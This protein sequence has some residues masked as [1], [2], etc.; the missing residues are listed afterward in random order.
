MP[1]ITASI[2]PITRIEGH[3]KVDVKIDTVNGVQQVVEAYSVGT[4]FRGFEKILEG[5]APRDA[6]IITSRICGVC[7]TAH[8]MA[9]S[10]TLDAAYGIS[11]DTPARTASRLLRNLVHGACFLE[12][13]I[14]HFYLLSLP[15][16]IPV[17]PMAPWLPGWDVGR[18]FDP[19][20]L[21]RFTGNFV[22]AVAARRNCHEMGA[23]YGGKLP[24]TPA[25][26]GG[27]G[28]TAVASASNNAAFQ[29]YLNELI[30]FIQTRYI[31]DSELLA[32][33]Y[34]EYL[35]L[36]K[37]Y[38]HLL[39]FGTF[40]LDNGNTPQTLFRR[41]RL[42]NGNP[43]VQ[44]VDVSQ[45]TEQIKHSWYSSA[46]NLNPAAGDTVPQNPK[47]GAYS[48][49]KAPRYGGVPYEVGPLARMAVN[50]EYTN[51]VST[52]DRHLARAREALKIALAMRDWLAGLVAGQSAYTDA[53][54]PTSATAVGLT[55]AP[56]GALGHWLQVG[57]S[58]IAKYQ[59]ITPTCWN[60]SP[61]DSSDQRGPL[62]Q[63]LIGLPVANVDKPIEVL[64]VVHSYDPCL[65]CAVH[66]SRAEPG[67]RVF[68][69][70]AMPGKN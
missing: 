6:T 65:D 12:S 16:Y 58:V 7:P 53:P 13:A 69:L 42:L 49:L 23:I 59:V 19:D 28:F 18:R 57:N 32:N 39:A 34:S 33:L 43:T 46:D 35:T 22:S 56:R 64:R 11:G 48:W 70:G 25:Y 63:A 4:M 44:P 68:A 38:G 54:K 67:A 2:D 10:L 15:D 52:M 51:G 26:L 41:G 30:T 47:A 17:L 21:N 45:I 20:T 60:L 24:H 31:P 29:G 66:V 14:L 55:E 27:G 40:E 1:V 3:L 36:G 37:G 9:S 61:K 5:R 62:E 50:G 8:G